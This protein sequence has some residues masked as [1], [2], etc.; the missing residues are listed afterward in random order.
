[1][2]VNDLDLEALMVHDD[3]T[4]R[5]VHHEIRS[6]DRVEQNQRPPSKEI[7]DFIESWAERGKALETQHILR[8]ARKKHP[9]ATAEM[10]EYALKQLRR[11]RDR[12]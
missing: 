2:E 8:E 10:I 12:R 7:Y 5:P 9:E 1:V 6:S 4:S 11:V 3:D